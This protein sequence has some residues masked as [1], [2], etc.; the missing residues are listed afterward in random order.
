MP[1]CL[2]P[3]PSESKKSEKVMWEV[4]DL[5]TLLPCAVFGAGK[6]LESERS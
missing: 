1:L 6:L 2:A 4:C 3:A 5:R